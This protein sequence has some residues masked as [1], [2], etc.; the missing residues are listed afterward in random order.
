MFLSKMI[1]WAGLDCVFVKSRPST[2]SCLPGSSWHGDSSTGCPAATLTNIL[3]VWKYWR[4]RSPWTKAWHESWS[5]SIFGLW[6]V[7][8]PH[9]VV[10]L[11]Q[12]HIQLDSDTS[13]PLT[14]HA[15]C[16]FSFQ[17]IWWAHL[18]AVNGYLPPMGKFP[19]HHLWTLGGLLEQ[20]HTPMEYHKGGYDFI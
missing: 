9:K 3:I 13:N 8:Q 1:L 12:I 16:I 14:F 6:V 11:K 18:E 7:F 19:D 20:L 10:L 2:F 15:L 4:C 17:W 5:L